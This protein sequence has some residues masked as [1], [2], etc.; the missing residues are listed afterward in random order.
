MAERLSQATSPGFREATIELVLLADRNGHHRPE[1]QP[2]R[3]DSPCGRFHRLVWLTAGD[4][5]GIP[6]LSGSVVAWY[7][8]AVATLC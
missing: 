3:T 6:N 5:V 4:G 8:A 2:D 1:G 7:G